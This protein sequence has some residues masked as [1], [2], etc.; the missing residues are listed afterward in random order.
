MIKPKQSDDEKSDFFYVLD[1]NRKLI[2]GKKKYFLN[3]S[4]LKTQKIIWKR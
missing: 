4:N 2:N 3:M 1:I